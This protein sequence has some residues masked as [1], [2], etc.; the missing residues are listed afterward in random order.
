MNFTKGDVVY[1][2]S[3]SPAMTVRG[4]AWYEDGSLDCYW[5]LCGEVRH[6]GFAS[7]QLTKEKPV[8]KNEYEV[9]QGA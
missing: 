4:N 6:Y 8:K 2:K 9:I 1:L 3:G 5:F 7:E